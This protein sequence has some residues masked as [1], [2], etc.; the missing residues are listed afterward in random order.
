MTVQLGNGCVEANSG[1][2]VRRAKPTRWCSVRQ[3]HRLQNAT[4]D[5]QERAGHVLAVVAQAIDGVRTD[6]ERGSFI[7]AVHALAVDEAAAVV[8][9]FAVH[10]DEFAPADA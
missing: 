9:R 6:D 5:G 8:E 7:H 2:R 1:K 4:A 3:R 10:P